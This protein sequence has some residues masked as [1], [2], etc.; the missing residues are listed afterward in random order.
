MPLPDFAEYII[1][2][3]SPLGD[4]TAKRMFSGILLSYNGQQIGVV[5]G[6]PFSFVFPR[7][8]SQNSVKPDRYHL[9]TKRKLARS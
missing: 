7:L 5:W 1:D 3:L 6:S 4:I 2:L 9:P 8:S